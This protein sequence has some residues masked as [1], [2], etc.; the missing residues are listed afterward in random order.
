VTIIGAEGAR[1]F[2]E[3]QQQLK[4]AARERLPG[5]EREH[6]QVWDRI[7]AND[8]RLRDIRQQLD[9]VPRD[10]VELTD[11]AEKQ[12]L[13]QK[14]HDLLEEQEAIGLEQVGLKQKESELNF[15]LNEAKRQAH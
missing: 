15:G 14:R 7:R 2:R 11:P 6:R 5:L 12:A 10:L 9:R 8:A 1:R 3:Q 4:A 13:L